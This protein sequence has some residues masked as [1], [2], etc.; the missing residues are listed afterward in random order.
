LHLVARVAE[1][2]FKTD[3]ARGDVETNT[4]LSLHTA[5][6]GVLAGA[7]GVD[8]GAD[9]VAA[10]VHTLDRHAF[11]GRDKARCVS[12]GP[13]LVAVAIEVELKPSIGEFT[14]G[15]ESDLTRTARAT[16]LGVIVGGEVLLLTRGDIEL[17]SL[18]AIE[19]A[20]DLAI[21]GSNLIEAS[22]LLGFVGFI[23]EGGDVVVGVLDI[24]IDHHEVAAVVVRSSDVALGED[25]GNGSSLVRLLIILTA[26]EGLS[27]AAARAGGWGCLLVA[28]LLLLLR[29]GGGRSGCG[30]SRSGLLTS[31]GSRRKRLLVHEEIVAGLNGAV[32]VPMS[33]TTGMSGRTEGSGQENGGSGELHREGLSS[34]RCRNLFELTCWLGRLAPRVDVFARIQGPDQVEW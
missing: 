29:L 26:T 3:L 9:A 17:E 4:I 21:F 8:G 7:T 15:G 19:E 11:S 12:T 10:N 2:D 1:G 32:G 6:V 27:I 30:S 5:E 33:M 13:A 24:S 22:A 18:L 34:S 16:A 23:S 31:G 25:I 28:G 14:P 20:I